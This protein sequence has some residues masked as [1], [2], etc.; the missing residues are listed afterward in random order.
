MKL[1]FTCFT[2]VKTQSS[3][4]Q[5]EGIEGYMTQKQKRYT[6]SND[7]H[8]IGMVNNRYRAQTYWVEEMELPKG[9]LLTELKYLSAPF[10]T[11]LIR[12]IYL[13]EITCS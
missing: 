4:E 1:V 2:Q 3:D 13:R 9:K 8:K 11:I 6:A 5:R 10:C 7:R 12:Y